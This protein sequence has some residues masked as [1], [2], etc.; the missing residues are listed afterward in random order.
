MK[1]KKVLSLLV[2]F[3]QTTQYLN[4]IFLYIICIIPKLGK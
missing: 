3:I 4:V 2:N 1:T